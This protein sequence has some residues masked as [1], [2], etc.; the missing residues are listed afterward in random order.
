VSIEGWSDNDRRQW[1]ITV[2]TG[3]SLGNLATGAGLFTRPIVLAGG[4]IVEQ[5]Q[6]DNCFNT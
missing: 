6:D 3:G 2:A 5:G 4:S 1:H